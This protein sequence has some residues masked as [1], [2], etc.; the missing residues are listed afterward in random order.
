LNADFSITNCESIS[1]IS[2][3]HFRAEASGYISL[4]GNFNIEADPGTNV[5]VDSLST[6]ADYS[7]FNWTYYFN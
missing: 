5:Q 6:G 3:A 7:K 1:E 2:Q 4:F